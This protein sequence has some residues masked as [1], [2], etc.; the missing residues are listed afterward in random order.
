MRSLPFSKDCKLTLPIS[1]HPSLKPFTLPLTLLHLRLAILT[2]K[3]SKYIRTN[4]RRLLSTLPALSPTSPASTAAA[5]Y[6]LQ[7][8][9]VNLPTAGIDAV[10]STNTT[11]TWQEKVQAWQS[12]QE[13]ATQ[14]GDNSIR[15]LA[16]LAEAQLLLVHSPSDY[17]RAGSILS[18]LFSTLGG[19]S[20]S[21]T[22]QWPRTVKVLYRLL[23]CLW[24]S[25]MGEAKEAKEVLKSTHK[26]LDAQVEQAEM[27]SDAVQVRFM[28]NRFERS[29]AFSRCGTDNWTSCAS[30]RLLS[31]QT[32]MNLP[33]R[34]PF[35]SRLIRRCIPLRFSPVRYVGSTCCFRNPLRT[36]DEAASIRL[37]YR[38]S[39]ST[40]SAN[41]LVP[42]FSR[43]KV[44]GLHRASSERAKVRAAASLASRTR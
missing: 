4:L 20:D 12:V 30:H 25:Q 23:Y 29:G 17:S 18:S 24:K 8:F 41:R 11:A 32:A 36:A 22:E 14:R 31:Q 2:G 39:T 21:S 37:M 33:A 6:A 3:P 16:L 42:G 9:V 35:A 34:W 26:L 15:V 27:E 40:R 7:S 28:V 5:H 10:V 13:L 43:K 19:D 44:C 38:P 1:Q